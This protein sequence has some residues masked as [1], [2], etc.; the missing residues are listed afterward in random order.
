MSVSSKSRADEKEKKVGIAD[1]KKNG[2][3]GEGKQ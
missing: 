3:E 1:D 2:K